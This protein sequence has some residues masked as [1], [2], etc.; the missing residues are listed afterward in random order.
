MG[1]Y[2]EAHWLGQQNE[3]PGNIIPWKQGQSPQS[4]EVWNAAQSMSLMSWATFHLCCGVRTNESIFVGFQKFCACITQTLN[5]ETLLQKM[6]TSAKAPSR[7]TLPSWSFT[8]AFTPLLAPLLTHFCLS[9]HSL[10][11]I[12]SFL[13]SLTVK[14]PYWL[15]YSFIY[16]HSFINL[17]THTRAHT[18][19]STYHVFVCLLTFSV[20]IQAQGLMHARSVLDHPPQSIAFYLATSLFCFLHYVPQD[21]LE[22][23]VLLPQNPTAGNTPVLHSSGL[24]HFPVLWGWREALVLDSQMT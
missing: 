18:H 19:L 20:R 21:G 8:L 7:Q 15:T 10:L 9:I 23:V 22:L 1:V 24:K 5:A 3:S 12:H 13:S 4:Q 6:K 17:H 2:P 11:T 16:T 14:H